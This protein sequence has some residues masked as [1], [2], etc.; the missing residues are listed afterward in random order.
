[1]ARLRL[2]LCTRISLSSFLRALPGPLQSLPAAL[3]GREDVFSLE[4]VDLGVLY[5]LHIR[6]DNAMPRP[7]WFLD[8]VEVTDESGDEEFVFLCERWLSANKEDGKVERTLYEQGSETVTFPCERWLAR[9]EEDG[10]VVRE[11]APA[12]VA[13]E[14]LTEDGKLERTEEE[15]ED[16]L[17]GEE[18][19]V[20]NGIN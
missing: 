18:D 16:P 15:V 7:D 5:K 6:H 12:E 3:P 19:S 10:E 13:V 11:L 20:I 8:R 4:A 14:R 2:L 9:S 1:M 17:E